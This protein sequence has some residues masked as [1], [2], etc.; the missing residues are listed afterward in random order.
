MNTS[1]HVLYHIVVIIL[2]ACAAL[3]LPYTVSFMAKEFLAVWSFI[4][5]EKI[6]LVSIEIAFAMLLIFTLNYLGSSWKN[7]KLAN[8]AKRAGLS[9]APIRKGRL[10]QK[11][12]KRAKERQGTDRD[13]MLMGSTGF[14][15][16]ADPESDL[17]KVIKN[18]REA[19]IMLLNPFSEGAAVRA[20]SIPDQDV[21]IDH[22]K[23]QIK[24]SIGF[25]KEINSVRKNIKLKLYSDSPFLKLNIIGDHVWVKHYQA[26]RDITFMPE[27]IF[28]HEQKD[29]GFYSLF[30]KYFLRHWNN[31]D[32]PEY[33]LDSDV[34][35]YRHTGGNEI[36]REAFH[37]ACQ[38]L[39]AGAA[40]AREVI[41]EPDLWNDGPARKAFA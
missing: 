11:R 39:S 2:S 1:L 41:H 25:L 13:I 20:A 26:G 6:F 7:R 32:I 31:P 27:Y 4:E 8:A 29:H 24:K 10:M 23:E 14:R 40:S 17:H 35:V 37:Q 36:K 19:K 34:L 3:S 18:C 28:Q 16:F 15:T 33:D 5:N 12:L 22:F 21:T 38:G 9:F 30:Y